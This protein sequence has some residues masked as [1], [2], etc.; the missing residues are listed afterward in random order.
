MLD[1]L[2]VGF[3]GF[4]GSILR[5]LICR[6]PLK[7]AGTFPFSTLIINVAGAFA[8]GFLAA[9]IS[10]SV[11]LNP[12]YALFW[13]VGICGGFTTFST[14]SLEAL[15]LFQNGKAWTGLSYILLSV[16]LG[17]CA[18]VFGMSLCK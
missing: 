8:L 13:K 10:K 2:F 18:A 3:G 12:R 17:I 15:T 1:C 16:T 6:I 9:Y 7:H 5:Y 11:S 4:I 14:F